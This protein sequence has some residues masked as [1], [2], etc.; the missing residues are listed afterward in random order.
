VKP[1]APEIIQPA[2]LRLF[3]VRGQTVVL[4]SDLAALCGVSTTAFNQAIKRNLVRFPSDFTFVLHTD[5]F[6]ALISQ[7]VTSKGRGGRR[8]LPRV[9]TEHGAIMAATILIS[10]RAVAMSV[11][12]VRAF[13][14]MREELLGR[15]NLERRLA[16]I[17]RTLV[18]HDAAL[19]DV[20]RKLKPLLLPPPAKPR[21]E[22]GFHAVAQPLHSPT[23]PPNRSADSAHR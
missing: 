6:R 9:F 3:A 23:K 13:V 18:G 21:G 17:E 16:E 4:D 7:I 10:P 15:A 14:R 5:E 8:K 12:V 19:R 1:A 20:Y 2:E 11:Y 22:I